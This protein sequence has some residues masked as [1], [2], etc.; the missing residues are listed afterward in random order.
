[1]ILD[2]GVVNCKVKSK[3]YHLIFSPSSVLPLFS[4]VFFF[5]VSF[6]RL[7]S[8]S[9]QLVL[10]SALHAI[11]SVFLFG[12]FQRLCLFY[13]LLKSSSVFFVPFLHVGVIFF[14]D[15]SHL[16]YFRDRFPFM[17]YSWTSFFFCFLIY[18]FVFQQINR[19]YVS[20]EIYT[21]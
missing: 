12:S 1:M 18:V 21:A 20:S 19:L 11:S 5:L 3:F 8:P 14:F 13:T 7:F 16:L 4:S 10:F 15:Q 17:A 9:S 6:D 2:T